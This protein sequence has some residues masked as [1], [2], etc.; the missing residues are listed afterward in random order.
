MHQDKP[1]VKMR[2]MRHL[3]KLLPDAFHCDSGEES[4]CM[5]DDCL[6][7]VL[8]YGEVKAR[9]IADSAYHP[10]AVL[11]KTLM[12]IAN[13]ADDPLSQISFAFHVII[14]FFIYGIP[15]HAIDRKIA[16]E[17]IFFWSGFDDV[18]GTPAIGVSRFF[19]KS[20]HFEMVASFHDDHDSKRNPD[21]NRFGKERL[22]LF[23]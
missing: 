8:I 23:H 4:I 5:V 13:G 15:E 17:R 12:R 3:F 18:C 2:K 6:L 10:Q 1:A 14:E 19:A 11:K 22:H 20:R 9:R 21:R 7:C 16:P